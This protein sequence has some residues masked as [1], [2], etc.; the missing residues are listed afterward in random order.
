MGIPVPE[1]RDVSSREGGCICVSAHFAVVPSI[2]EAKSRVGD[3]L[4]GVGVVVWGVVSMI[5][6]VVDPGDVGIGISRRGGLVGIVGA[7]APF[8]VRI[9]LIMY[10]SVLLWSFMLVWDKGEGCQILDRAWRSTSAT[11]STDGSMY[12]AATSQVDLIRSSLAGR[13]SRLARCEAAWTSASP[14]SGPRH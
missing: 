6:A 12:P 9:V 14:M 4:G 5:G 7:R 10:F 13:E 3:A 8:F 11:R 1:T 2:R